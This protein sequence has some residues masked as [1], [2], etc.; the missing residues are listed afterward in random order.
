MTK[1]TVVNVRYAPAFDVYMGRRGPFG[2]PYV[3]GPDGN[4][5]EVIRKFRVHFY[6]RLKIDPAW[7]KLVED[8]RGKRLA[9]HCTP[10]ACHVD[11][12]IEYLESP[13]LPTG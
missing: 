12:Y 7:K 13:G 3:I 8:L 1:T 2:N 6:E 4:R 10:M 5:E 11:V 9:C